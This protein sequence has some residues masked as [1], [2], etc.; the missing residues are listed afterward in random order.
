MNPEEIIKAYRDELAALDRAPTGTTLELEIR[1]KSV[2]SRASFA[3]N[4][5]VMRAKYGI[6][7]ISNTIDVITRA[8]GISR[9]YR[10]RETEPKREYAQKETRFTVIDEERQ[11]KVSISRESAVDAFDPVQSAFVRMKARLSFPAGKWRIDM[12]AT[13]EGILRDIGPSLAALKSRFFY[14]DFQTFV[15]KFN[16]NEATGYEMEIEYVAPE[17][18]EVADF[19]IIEDILPREHNFQ[20]E[21]YKV[22]A[23]IYPHRNQLHRF[24]EDYNVKQLTNQVEGLDKYTYFNNVYPPDGYVLTEKANGVRAVA[25][26]QG[27]ECI[28]FTS[29]GMTRY[30]APVQSATTVVDAELMIIDGHQELY[31]FDV[32]CVSGNRVLDSDFLA[33]IQHIPAAADILAKYL[34]A[35]AKKYTR[36][37][38]TT[39]EEQ[40]RGV[41]EAKYPYD[42]DGIIMANCGSSY[43]KTKHY[44]WKPAEHMTIDFL[45]IKCPKQVLGKIPYT[46]IAGR[47]L[48]LLHNGISREDAHSLG[49]ARLPFMPKIA[50]TSFFPI[51]FSPSANLLAYLYYHDPANGEIDGKIIELSREAN[52]W[53]FHK[54]REDRKLERVSFGNAFRV[55]ELNYINY[56]DPFEFRDLY[57]ESQSYFAHSSDKTDRIY[58]IPNRFK[59]HIIGG[60]ILRLFS[61]SKYLIDLGAGRGADLTRYT[62]AKITDV[63][64]I[65][66]DS[67]AISELIHRKWTH[68]FHTR[69]GG[70]ECK[71]MQIDIDTMFPHSGTQIHAS[72]FDLKESPEALICHVSQF[73][74]QLGKIDGIVSNFAFHYLCDTLAHMRGI[75]S[76]VSAMLKPQGVFY[77]TVMDGERVFEK[78]ADIAYGEAWRVSENDRVKYSITKK[79]KST[80]IAQYGQMI[81]VMLPFAK[82]AYDEPLCNVS[83]VS[84]EAEKLG[85]SCKV[86]SFEKY[87][88]AGF[89]GREQLTTGDIEYINLHC[90]VIFAKKQT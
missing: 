64:L 41:Y 60:D 26:A 25:Y 10:I 48:Y 78:L 53:K 28:V 81:S 1:V 67:L 85:M 50:D 38:Q 40:F 51:Q 86:I 89:I 57:T 33:R 61:G 18:P 11:L 9:I 7:C 74:A 63:L 59:R 54:I 4:I 32:M 27:G 90:A 39:L 83:A 79:Y 80:R 29:A 37:V 47:E 58:V 3:T 69:R 46:L 56:I 45:A 36:L 12:T 35:H 30:T 66:I 34:P 71:P 42:I 44:K 70:V 49:L 24:A 75:L 77:I 84:A 76:F 87:S 62:A 15:E 73:G 43:Y 21:I 14:K 22:A 19:A 16:Y 68:T 20:R 88:S 52:T 5:E 65:D 13:R 2:S 17:P 6:P 72:V 8:A 23:L 55:A 31:I 82:V